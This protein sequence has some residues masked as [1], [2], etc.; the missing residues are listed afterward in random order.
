MVC[1]YE[2]PFSEPI[3]T[4]AVDVCAQLGFKSLKFYNITKL[5]THDSIVPI[6][7]DIQKK[8]KHLRKYFSVIADDNHHFSE[9]ERQFRLDEHALKARTLFIEPV[10]GECFGL[11]VECEAKAYKVEPIKTVSAGEEVSAAGLPTSVLQPDLET[12]GKPNVFVTP[13]STL[14][15]V[16]KKDEMLNKL[17]GVIE[18]RRNMLLLIDNKLHEA[19]E[20]L[21]WPWVVDVYV[22]GR[23]WCVGAL[24]DKYW[25]L[26]H[27]SCHYG[28]R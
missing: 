17:D 8:N 24:V 23:L 5:T 3:F 4:T 21:H 26:V 19:V 12:H 18:S 22:D 15:M 28:V 6:H 13:P 27:E 20:E 2:I 9:T 7:P 10:K 1:S 16:K 25:V 11:F 14:I